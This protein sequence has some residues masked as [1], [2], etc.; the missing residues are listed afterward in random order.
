MKIKIDTTLPILAID[1]SY[2]ETAFAIFENKELKYIDRLNFKHLE[3]KYGVKLS[4]AYRRL[5][6]RKKTK[7]LMRQFN[8]AYIFLER[9][10]LFSKRFISIG[11][12]SALAELVATIVDATLPSNLILDENMKIIPVYSIDVRSWH[13]KVIGKANVTKDQVMKWAALKYMTY[14]LLEERDKEPFTENEA[15]ALGI[16]NFIYSEKD[17]L[18]LLKK[19]Q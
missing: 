18:H 11:S 12:I 6:I 2:V 8:I 14:E 3:E 7:L 13:S 16:G 17:I 10:R 19:E 9:V 1:Y 15:D 5:L 4:N